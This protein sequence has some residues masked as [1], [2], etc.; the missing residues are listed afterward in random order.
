MIAALIRAAMHQPWIVAI[1]TVLI[2]AVGVW[3]FLHQPTLLRAGGVGVY[4]FY[5]LLPWVGVMALGYAL[6]PIMQL[7]QSA[8]H[9]W[10]LGFGAGISVGFVRLR[11]TNL[12]GHPAAWTS[13]DSVLSTV[14]SFID[15]EKYPPSLLYV[16]MTLGPALVLLSFLERGT[17]RFLRPFLVFGRV[18]LFYYLLHLP[19]I[20]LL[21]V[22]IAL[23]R[24]GRAEWL[25]NNPFTNQSTRIPPDNGFGLLVVY[26]IWIMIVLALYPVCRWFAKIKRTHRS[27]WLSYL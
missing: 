3:A 2:M 24:Y 6:G 23:I 20:H 17:P 4:P 10:L 9:R 12:Y 15:C 18:P 7:E 5:S 25:F 16:L 26:L 22:I 21:A 14:L 11:A 19:L 27:V 1:V 13:H 8:R